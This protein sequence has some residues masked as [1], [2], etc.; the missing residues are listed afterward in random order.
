MKTA[1][2]FNA[3]VGLTDGL[4]LPQK[5]TLVEILTKRLIEQRRQV[6][7]KDILETRREYKSGR[8]RAATPIELMKEIMK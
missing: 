2:T 8:C 7:Q 6:L 4:S 3:I 5:E 1:M